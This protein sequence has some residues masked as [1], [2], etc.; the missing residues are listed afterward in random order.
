MPDYVQ[1]FVMPLFKRRLLSVKSVIQTCLQQAC[2]TFEWVG[3][4]PTC[5]DVTDQCKHTLES[6]FLGI[7]CY[8]H[9]MIELHLH[10]IERWGGLQC[11]F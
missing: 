3:G 6:V 9:I 8:K 5:H 4:R 10:M 1:C 7:F 11:I 2:A